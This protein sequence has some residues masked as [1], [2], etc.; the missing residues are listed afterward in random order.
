MLE[1]HH[2]IP[3]HLKGSDDPVNLIDICPNCHTATHDL[4]R[5]LKKSQA[6]AAEYLEGN[7]PGNQK[8]QKLLI[9]LAKVIIAEEDNEP[10]KEFV[11]VP[12]TLPVSIH[13]KLRDSSRLAKC[14]MH[15]Y[16]EYLIE[17]DYRGN[18]TARGS[19]DLRKK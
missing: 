12:L 1:T 2:K 4:S 6:K 5:L 15:K 11:K 18:N 3:R 10:E 9:Q 17:K 16:I 8:A 7:Y 13:S 19:F 14:S